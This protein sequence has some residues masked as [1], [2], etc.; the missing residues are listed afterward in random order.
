MQ[1]RRGECSQP[2][3]TQPSEKVNIAY[4]FIIYIKSALTLLVY[5][6]LTRVT[7]FNV[8][9]RLHYEEIHILKAN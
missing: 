7:G 4:Q 9:R 3:T 6:G 5:R 1:H 2:R 8:S